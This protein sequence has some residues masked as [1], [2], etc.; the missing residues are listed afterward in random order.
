MSLFPTRRVALV[1]LAGLGF[2][3][4]ALAQPSPMPALGARMPVKVAVP[5]NLY[6]RLEKGQPAGIFLEAIQAV[7]EG[8]GRQP[9]HV[10][11]PT[12][13]ALTE[14]GASGGIGGRRCHAPVFASHVPAPRAALSSRWRL[15]G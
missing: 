10:I 3:R 8:M 5:G 15:G 2:G 7:L 1:G 11:M 9:S 13:E 14:L 4:P 12:G 6:A